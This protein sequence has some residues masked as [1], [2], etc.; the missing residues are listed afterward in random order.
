[1]AFLVVRPR[2]SENN[3]QSGPNNVYEQISQDNFSCNEEIFERKYC[4]GLNLPFL[5]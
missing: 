1:M 2:K 3:L 4:K 5:N